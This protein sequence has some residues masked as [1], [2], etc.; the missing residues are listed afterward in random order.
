[1]P[2]ALLRLLLVSAALTLVGAAEPAPTPGA[3]TPETAAELVAVPPSTPS[4]AF[5]EKLE[6]AIAAYETKDRTA[7]PTPG[8]IEFIGSST[9]TRWTSLKSD[10]APLPVFNR[11][12]GGS[13]VEHVLAAVPRI[14]LPYRPAV[15][16]Y[17][18]GD[19]NLHSANKAE[20]A[21][22]AKGFSDFVA[23]V[24][25]AQPTTRIIY[26]SIKPSPRRWSSWD[27][28]KAANA[29]VKEFCAKDPS[30]TF[31]DIGAA[32][33]TADGAIDPSLYVED[34]LHMTAA[35]YAKVTAVLKPVVESV[36]AQAKPH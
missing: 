36:W 12:F 3:L 1:M 9:F 10:F 16:V 7:P 20:P 24:H 11:A 34:Q 21:P 14:V 17:Y 30:L 31:V 6:K 28:A 26:M 5:S 23:A 8:T 4:S 22:I 35:G 2:S 33:L 19:N 27:E 18:C 32:L 29:L 13:R 15:I 25:A